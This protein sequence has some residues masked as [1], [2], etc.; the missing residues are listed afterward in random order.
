LCLGV[1]FF[2]TACAW[3]PPG[4]RGP[5]AVAA[6]QREFPGTGRACSGFSVGTPRSRPPPPARVLLGGHERQAEPV[7]GRDAHPVHRRGSHAGRHRGPLPR[8][9]PH[10]R[11]ACTPCF[12]SRVPASS[13]AHPCLSVFAALLSLPPLPPP[14]VLPP[15]PPLPPLPPRCLATYTATA[16]CFHRR[17][18]CCRSS[19]PSRT[20]VPRH[21]RAPRPAPS[22]QE[23][24]RNSFGVEWAVDFAPECNDPI[25]SSL[26]GVL[27]SLPG[28]MSRVEVS[29][30]SHIAPPLPSPPAVATAAAA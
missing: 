26:P 28:S 22:P 30:T 13:S 5:C 16:A 19:P 21:R 2:S 4:A 12:N 17:C 20:H 24:A 23:R 10:S 8:L 7:G 29:F 25:V 6:L 3:W 18:R 9:Q 1:P 14:H 27:P 11:G 15:R